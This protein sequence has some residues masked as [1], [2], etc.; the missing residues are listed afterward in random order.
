VSNQQVEL[1]LTVPQSLGPEMAYL[2]HARTTLGALTQMVAQT[3]HQ[4]VMAAPYIKGDIFGQGILQSA[5]QHAVEERHVQLSIVTT[6]ESL[7]SFTNIDWI[8][9]NRGRVRLFRPKTNVD[10]EQQL[11]SHAKFCIADGQTAYIGSANLTFLGLHQHL[12]MG[13]LLH[14]ELAKQVS[15]LWRLLTLNEFFVLVE[16]FV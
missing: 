14:G 3:Q 11:G 1:V 2:A 16:T 9:A 10:I 6:G 4:L 13:V 7:D 12:E 8:K 15:D 5:L